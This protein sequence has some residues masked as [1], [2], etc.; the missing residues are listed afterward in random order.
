MNHC[1]YIQGLEGGRG[2][3]CVPVQL[4]PQRFGDPD[5]VHTMIGWSDRDGKKTPMPLICEEHTGRLFPHKEAGRYLLL[6]S[7]QPHVNWKRVWV[8]Q[9]YF[10]GLE[11]SPLYMRYVTSTSAFYGVNDCAARMVRKLTGWKVRQTYPYAPIWLTLVK[12]A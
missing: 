11:S 1:K 10:K 5:V 3:L 12:A 6:A 8:G 9:T 4:C 7:T 2:F